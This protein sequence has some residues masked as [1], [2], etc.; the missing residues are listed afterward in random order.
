MLVGA[1]QIIFILLVIFGI[2]LLVR[3]RMS[4]RLKWIILALPVFA[5]LIF[6]AFIATRLH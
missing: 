2:T 4:T 6:A 3:S 5:I 1:I